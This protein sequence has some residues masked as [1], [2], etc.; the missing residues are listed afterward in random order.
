MVIRPVTRTGARSRKASSSSG[1]IPLFEPSPARLTSTRISVAGSPW[2]SSWRS[3]ESLAT[4]WISR[5]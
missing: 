1:A 4:D 2:R 3:A 5:T